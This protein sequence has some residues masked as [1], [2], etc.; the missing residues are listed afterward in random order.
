MYKTGFWSGWKYIADDKGWVLMFNN[1]SAKEYIE[2]K[3]KQ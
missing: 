1:Q 2:D 3:L